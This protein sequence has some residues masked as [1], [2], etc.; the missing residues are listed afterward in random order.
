MALAR[1]KGKYLGIKNDE[2]SKVAGIQPNKLDP[3]Y[4]FCH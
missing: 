4:R 2:I 3:A 1:V